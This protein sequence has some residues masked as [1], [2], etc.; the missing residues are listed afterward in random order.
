MSSSNKRFRMFLLLSLTPR[1]STLYLS[2]QYW[3]WM[4]PKQAN[5]RLRSLRFITFLHSRFA[6]KLYLSV[7]VLLFSIIFEPGFGYQSFKDTSRQLVNKTIE[8]YYIQLYF[9]NKKVFYAPKLNLKN[10][11][12]TH[13]NRCRFTMN[14]NDIILNKF[15]EKS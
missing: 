14:E 6:H 10:N 7:L 15:S 4:K 11:V 9:I 2:V 3:Q 5:L 8:E 12:V 13:E 1:L